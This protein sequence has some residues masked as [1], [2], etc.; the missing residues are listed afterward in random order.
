MPAPDPKHRLTYNYNV[1]FRFG[2]LGGL[3]RDYWGTTGDY[4]GTTGRLL[5]DYWKS[6]E[7][8]TRLHVLCRVQVGKLKGATSV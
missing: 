1:L 6:S 4:R 8:K 2:D 3:L 5:G 7:T